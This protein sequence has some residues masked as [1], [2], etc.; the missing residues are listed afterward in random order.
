[1]LYNT[2]LRA[3]AARFLFEETVWFYCEDSGWSQKYQEIQGAGP[4]QRE[5][6]PLSSPPPEVRTY[7]G[8]P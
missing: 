2:D 1:M 5:V 6:G 7:V 3:Q 4:G 8:G